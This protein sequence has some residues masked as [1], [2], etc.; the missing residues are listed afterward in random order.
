MPVL[1]KIVGICYLNLQILRL[2]LEKDKNTDLKINFEKL[3]QKAE[4]IRKKSEIKITNF[5]SK[6]EKELEL[7]KRNNPNFRDYDKDP[8][9]IKCYDE[10]F[11]LLGMGNMVVWILGAYLLYILIELYSGNFFSKINE[12]IIVG[13][14]PVGYT[15]AAFIIHKNYFS[16][17]KIKFT[18]MYIEFIHKGKIRKSC[19]I[20]IDQL[21]KPFFADA[22]GK[23][24]GVFG[25]LIF[26]ILNFILIISF[27][28]IGFAKQDPFAFF[29]VA[30]AY[31]ANFLIKFALYLSI[32]GN[33]KGF[34][35]FPCIKVCEQSWANAVRE[36]HIYGAH[37]IYLYNN[38]VYK[39][40]KKY[41]LQRNI[42]IDD[43]PIRYFQIFV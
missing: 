26:G 17:Y 37:L 3:K 9:I 19:P 43:L 21:E 11:W 34:K 40:V 42:N 14:L 33:L 36:V 35:F 23:L 39:E 6:K 13:F 28:I 22:R 15:I 1:R 25:N 31:L 29:F 41:F 5:E 30:F 20:E 27:F 18:N 24:M 7:Q 2:N 16:D 8:L 32:N 38:E 4:Q 12:F 10:I